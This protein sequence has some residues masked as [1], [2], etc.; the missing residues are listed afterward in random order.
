M[1]AVK[2]IWGAYMWYCKAMWAIWSTVSLPKKNKNIFSLE[3]SCFKKLL[4][5]TF[6]IDK[7]FPH[8]SIHIGTC[9]RGL[10]CALLIRLSAAETSALL[11]LACFFHLIPSLF[12]IFLFSVTL[13][14]IVHVFFF[15]FF[16]KGESSSSVLVLLCV[17]VLCGVLNYLSVQPNPRS[18]NEG[19]IFF[20]TYTNGVELGRLAD[21]PCW[22]TACTPQLV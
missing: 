3:C 6:T 7:N 9:S 8:P 5:L 11:S 17:Q 15:F 10:G 20:G 1:V 2:G 21:H 16:I 4:V 18:C 13:K 14:N 19:C 22:R 12:F